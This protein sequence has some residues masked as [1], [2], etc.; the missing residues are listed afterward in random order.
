MAGIRSSVG[1]WER[2]V[3][4]KR[5]GNLDTHADEERRSRLL[6]AVAQIMPKALVWYRQQDRHGRFAIMSVYLFF[7]IGLLH[8]DEVSIGL[9]IELYQAMAGKIEMQVRGIRGAITIDEDN[10]S[11]VLMQLRMLTAMQ[12]QWPARGYCQCSFYGNTDVNSAFPQKRR[13]MG[14]QVPLLC[15]Q[16]S[17]CPACTASGC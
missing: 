4:P 17:R 10:K 6:P 8:L 14:E 5:R 15:F 3:G 2:G 7:G 1:K 12:A 11:W 13:L 9:G 16:K